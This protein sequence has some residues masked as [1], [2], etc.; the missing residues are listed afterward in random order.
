MNAVFTMVRLNEGSSVKP[1]V[2]VQDRQRRFERR[3]HLVFREL[4]GN[5]NR[6]FDRI[7][8]GPAMADDRYSAQS[9]ERGAAVL[10]VVEPLLHTLKGLLAEEGAD[11]GLKVA[12]EFVSQ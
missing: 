5:P 2:A 7:A 8:A 11:L 9:D 6:M 10:R 1:F 4:L 3:V 12:G